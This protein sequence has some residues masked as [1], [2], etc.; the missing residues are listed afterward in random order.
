MDR[1]RNLSNKVVGN[2]IVQKLFIEKYTLGFYTNDMK[3]FI[4]FCKENR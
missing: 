1:Q 4:K 3:P 2:Y